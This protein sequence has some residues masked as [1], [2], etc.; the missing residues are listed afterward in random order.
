VNLEGNQV[1]VLGIDLVELRAVQGRAADETWGQAKKEGEEPGHDVWSHRNGR[2][3]SPAFAPGQGAL[4]ILRES[5]TPAS[6]RGEM[7]RDRQG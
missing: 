2:A 1:P 5:E 6:T 7:P 3:S 4:G